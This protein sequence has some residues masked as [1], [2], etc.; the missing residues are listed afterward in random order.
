MG[1]TLLYVMYRH[2]YRRIVTGEQ[3][4]TPDPP[5]SVPRAPYRGSDA[6]ACPGGMDY[7]EEVPGFVPTLLGVLGMGSA[8]AGGVQRSPVS[9]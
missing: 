9:D 7:G 5:D 6:D 3:L 2:A 1:G 8:G 4:C